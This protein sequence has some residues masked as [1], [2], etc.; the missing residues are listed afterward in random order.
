ML[1]K[2]RCQHCG[3]EY[4][5][6]VELGTWQKD[7]TQKA[8]TFVGVSCRKFCC[9]ECGKA[10][11]GE[12]ISKIW[13][14][15]SRAEITG[16]TKKRIKSAKPRICSVCGK[17]FIPNQAGGSKT[18]IYFCSSKCREKHYKKI[19][20]SGIRRCQNC[21]KEYM[22]IENQGSWNKN[23]ELVHVRGTGHEF[24]VKSQR[25]CCY[26]CG[27]AYKERKRK[28]S[29]L[30]RNGRESPFQDKELMQK[31]YE[32]KKSDGTLF[33]S[34][35]EKEITDWLNSLGIKSEKLV[36]GNGWADDSP[37]M[38]IDIYIPEK[39]LGIEY[40]GIYFHAIN[41]RRKGRMTECYHYDKSL[42]AEENGIELLHIW[43]DQWIRRPEVI[44][45]KILCRL[46]LLDKKISTE[47][48]EIKEIDAK[49]CRNFCDTN[50]LYSYRLSNVRLGLFK[51]NELVQAI[52]FRKRKGST[53]NYEIITN[54]IK[55]RL[56][57][58]N[59][60]TAIL[61]YFKQKYKPDNITCNVDWNI[62]NGKEYKDAGFSYMGDIY[63]DEFC[64]IN[65]HS[66]SRV[67][68]NIHNSKEY[69]EKT[70][71]DEVWLCYGAGYRIYSWK[72]LN[73]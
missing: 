41:G 56:E 7:G 11:R 46:G 67:M 15:K 17:E 63:P 49:T 55:T 68:L 16:I 29:N 53:A 52:S 73:S 4:E 18:G 34:K 26:E 50:D 8:G 66:Y 39:K 71:K 65:D 35:G 62:N 3:K 33:I 14:S 25:F 37:R 32:K 31:V 13:N 2:F 40:N 30:V 59:G 51:G 45:S 69:R 23:N 19:P 20:D 43:E 72:A 61:D 64:I 36:T 38:E 58:I 21:G 57:V 47:T 1:E 27:I 54:C 70:K 12:K 44:K 24:T 48:C 42:W 10:N 6:D 22:Y 60:T 9:Y 5:V 28:V